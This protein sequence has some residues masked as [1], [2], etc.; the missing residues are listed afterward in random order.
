MKS[1]ALVL[2]VCCFA[3][4][5]Q[6]QYNN[7][8]LQSCIAN[9][10]EELYNTVA[11]YKNGSI[12]LT[13]TVEGKPVIEERFTNSTIREDSPSN[14]YRAAS[15]TK[16]FTAT[17]LMI[18]VDEK[19]VSLDDKV[20]QYLPEINQLRAYDTKNP[21]TFKQLA[22]HT[23]GLEMYPGLASASKGGLSEWENIVLKAIPETR[24]EARTGDQ[25]I[26]SNMGYAVLGLALSKAAN[27]PY[28]QLIQEKIIAPLQLE[29]TFFEIPASHL[30]Q[31]NIGATQKKIALQELTDWGYGI[32]NG[33]IYSSPADI[34][35]LSNAILS[36]NIISEQSKE[37]MF[38]NHTNQA[39]GYGIGFFVFD[40]DLNK[41][42]ILHSGSTDG[43]TGVIAINKE[44]NIHVAILSNFRDK[45]LDWENK[46]VPLI[47]EIINTSF[48]I[49][50]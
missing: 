10:S 4:T 46:A 28:T 16:T 9:F 6:A 29:H 41:E 1:I 7:D 22:S 5:S 27:K 14:I 50:D 8:S 31:L 25:F 36:G 26:Y 18:L 40:D 11:Y 49:K 47:D 48:P 2:A 17:L 43:Y 13:I 32:P 37:L 23:S 30:S 24:I 21:I 19:V 44:Y 33:G 45:N 38:T 12:S 42:Y 3:L 15:I 20:E 39:F 34:I 35:T